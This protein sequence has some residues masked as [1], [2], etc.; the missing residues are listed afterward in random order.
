MV[1]E[2][3]VCYLWE[4]YSQ[5]YICMENGITCQAMETVRDLIQVDVFTFYLWG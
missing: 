4:V 1:H 2:F 5:L 3:S